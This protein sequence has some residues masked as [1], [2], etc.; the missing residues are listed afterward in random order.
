MAGIRKLP[1]SGT[2]HRLRKQGWTHKDIATEFKVSESAVWK[3]LMRAGYTKPMPTYRD[4][5]PWRIA[6][7]HKATAIME[8][9]RAIVKQQK[10]AV[11]R[12]DEE[13]MLNRWLRDLQA[14][15]L[16]VAYH[17]DAPPNTASTKGGFYYT[18]RTPE[19]D[20]IIRRPP[21]NE[22]EETDLPAENLS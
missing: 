22:T 11:L 18:P 2:L 15:N 17:P 19:D 9:F 7:E 3:A 21:A 16:V 4:L 12:L 20:W 8:H 5:L 1:D 13:Q 6:E 14:L 10:G